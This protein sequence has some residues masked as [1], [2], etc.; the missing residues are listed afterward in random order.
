MR[1]PDNL[2]QKTKVVLHGLQ[3]FVIF[4]SWAIIIAIFTKDGSTDGRIKYFF[5]LVRDLCRLPPALTSHQKLKAD[6]LPVLVLCSPPHLPNRDSPIRSCETILEC[7]RPRSHRRASR[8]VLVRGFHLC[9]DVDQGGNQKG[10]RQ[11]WTYRLRCLCLGR[12]SVQMSLKSSGYWDGGC[13]IVSLFILHQSSH[14]DQTK[15][16]WLI[17][18]GTQ[19]PVPGHILHL[20]QECPLLPPQRLPSRHHHLP[21]TT[22]PATGRR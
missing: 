8:G 4:L 1:L 18:D 20:H 22:P 15:L 7:L 21:P 14:D 10:G 2:L 12:R 17:M 5:A 9:R 13:A 16:R 11:T 6:C 3:G 19:S